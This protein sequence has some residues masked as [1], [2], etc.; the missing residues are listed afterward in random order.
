MTTHTLRSSIRFLGRPEVEKR[1]NVS[2]SKLYEEIADGLFVKPVT[3]GAG[4]SRGFPEHEVEMLNAARL[5]G[6]P[7]EEIR[8]LVKWLEHERQ[9]ALS[10]LLANSPA[11]RTSSE[12]EPGSETATATVQTNANR[13]GRHGR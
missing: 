5:A 8:R 2:R 9:F 6:K 10:D 4:R 11:Q 13:G 12:R 7:D 1:R 3:V